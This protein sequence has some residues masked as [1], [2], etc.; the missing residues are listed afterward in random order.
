MRQVVRKLKWEALYVRNRL[1]ENGHAT[2]V[3][4]G[5]WLAVGKEPYNAL[6]DWYINGV[7]FGDVEKTDKKG[8]GI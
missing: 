4:L 5:V 8:G 1:P 6:Q 2:K 3:W 7:D